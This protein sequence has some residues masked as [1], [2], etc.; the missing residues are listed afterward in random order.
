[1]SALTNSAGLA[2]LEFS[3]WRKVPGI[4][5][6]GGLVLCVLGAVLEPEAVR[7]FVAAG[8]HVLPEPGAG[9]RVPGDDAPPV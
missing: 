9:G 8:V 3:R 1:M 4:L 2:P 5:I 7:L 6:G